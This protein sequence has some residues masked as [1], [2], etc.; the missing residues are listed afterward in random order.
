MGRTLGSTPT[1]SVIVVGGAFAM[2][3]AYSLAT[4]GLQFSPAAFQQITPL[5]LVSGFAMMFYVCIITYLAPR[6]GVGN[7][8]MLVVAAQIAS[9]AAIDHFGLFGAPQK[10]I[11]LLRVS[12]LAIMMVGVVIAQCAVS[13]TRPAG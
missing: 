9:S 10:P 7:A 11:D 1:A 4:G 13:N 3:L 8:V 12:G 2:V 6:F 5:Q